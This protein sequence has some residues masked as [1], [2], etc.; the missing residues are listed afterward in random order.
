MR[1]TCNAASLAR[2]RIFEATRFPMQVLPTQDGKTWHR[3]AT[4]RRRFVT[5]PPTLCTEREPIGN[6]VGRVIPL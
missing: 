2:R 1:L 4:I 6:P 3:S 5:M